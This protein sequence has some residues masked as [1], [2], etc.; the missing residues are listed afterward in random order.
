VSFTELP[1]VAAL[2]ANEF[3][4]LPPTLFAAETD[5]EACDT[6]GKRTASSEAQRFQF[7][8]SEDLSD[9]HYRGD[10]EVSPLPFHL[11]LHLPIHLLSL[12]A[13]SITLTVSPSFSLL[14]SPSP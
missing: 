9:L 2:P 5:G 8:D 3:G 14:L 1:A 6:D 11:H 12:T 7:R 13:A 4:E 10:K